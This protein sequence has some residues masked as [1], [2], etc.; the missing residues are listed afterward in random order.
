[1]LGIFTEGPNV[2]AM[3]LCLD[4]IVKDGIKDQGDR[5]TH[6]VIKGWSQ[7]S[8]SKNCSQEIKIGPL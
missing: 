2:S 1:M 3:L 8:A 5:G 4:Q 6:A 7:G